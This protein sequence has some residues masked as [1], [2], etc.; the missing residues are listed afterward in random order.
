MVHSE[1]GVIPLNGHAALYIH[2]GSGYPIADCFRYNNHV[3]TMLHLS[4]AAV[5]SSTS[6][7][8][9][10]TNQYNKQRSHALHKS[11]VE[12]LED[13]TK[14]LRAKEHLP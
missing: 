1:D 9:S 4:F 3:K 7:P 6:L 12:R 14:P 10:N 11:E 8:L 2:Y 5:L 13:L